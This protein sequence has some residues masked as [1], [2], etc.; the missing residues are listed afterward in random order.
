[1]AL[2]LLTSAAHI[3]LCVFGFFVVLGACHFS[4]TVQQ[5]DPTLKPTDFVLYFNETITGTIRHEPLIWAVGSL[6]QSPSS[7]ELLLHEP[8]AGL[9]AAVHVGDE[10]YREGPVLATNDTYW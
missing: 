8:Y 6:S 7:V 10:V 4:I 9:A 1:M 3:S 2:H 5:N